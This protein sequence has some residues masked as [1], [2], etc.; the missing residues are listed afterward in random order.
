MSPDRLSRNKSDIKKELQWFKN[1]GIRLMI[2]DLPTTMVRI[3]EGRECLKMKSSSFCRM[4]KVCVERRVEP[5]GWVVLE[6]V[7]GNKETPFEREK[8]GKFY[9]VKRCSL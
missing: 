1:Q 2:L 6:H 8:D 9:S 7:P 3:P 5:K 4:V